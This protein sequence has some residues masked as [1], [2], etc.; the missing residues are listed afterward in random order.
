MKIKANER[1][2]FAGDSVTDD[3]RGRPV[4]EG[5]WDGVGNGYVRNVETLLSLDYPELNIRCTNM[6]IAGDTTRE[7]LARWD[8]IIALKPDWV[9]ICIG[10]NDVWRTFDTPTC[11]DQA[12]EPDE[13]ERNINTMLDRTAAK[14]VL[15]T[16]YFIESNKTDPMRVRMDKYGEIVKKIA[17]ERS[18]PCVDLQTP[19]DEVLKHR[20]PMSITWDRIHPGKLG[21]MVIARALL[22]E[23]GYKEK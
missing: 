9:V 4:G 1:I 21:S 10:F 8:D 7:L 5:L 20:H 15:M 2:V 17:K 18:L 23:F 12:V 11:P 13:Y 19:F 3:G 16:P 14:V 6:G 22:K